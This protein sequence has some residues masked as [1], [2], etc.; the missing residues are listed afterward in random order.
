M[1]YYNT[2]KSTLTSAR[3]LNSCSVASTVRFEQLGYKLSIKAGVCEGDKF[4]I[5]ELEIPHK[6]FKVVVSSEVFLI[7]TSL[8]DALEVSIVSFVLLGFDLDDKFCSILLISV[9]QFGSFSS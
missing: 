4:T 1:I 7:F 3:Y 5:L 8:T 9:V 6:S 2:V